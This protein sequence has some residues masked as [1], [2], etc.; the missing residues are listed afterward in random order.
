MRVPTST[1]EPEDPVPYNAPCQQ[2]ETKETDAS[3]QFLILSPY[4]SLLLKRKWG[5]D[6]TIMSPFINQ[7]PFYPQTSLEKLPRTA[8][9]SNRKSHVIRQL[10]P[11]QRLLCMH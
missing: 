1:Q 9:P 4:T 3:P 10:H 11:Y 2:E 7:W 5:N 6:G 8:L